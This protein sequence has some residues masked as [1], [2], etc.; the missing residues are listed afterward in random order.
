MNALS[1]L[2]QDGALTPEEEAELDSYIH[3]GNLLAVIQSKARR[4]LQAPTTPR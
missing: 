1:A 4:V 3:V 2:A